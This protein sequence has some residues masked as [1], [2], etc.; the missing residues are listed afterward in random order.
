M[1]TL[2]AALALPGAALATPGAPAD[3]G[4]QPPDATTSSGPPADLDAMF[5][6]AHPDDEAGTLS[7]F[8]QWNHDHDVT[9]GVITITRGEGGGNAV[10]PQEGPALGLI[11]ERE[12]RAAVVK[13]GITDVYNLD[14]VDFYY[15]VSEPLTAQV[16]DHEET[17]AKTVRILRQTR[18]GVLVTMNPAPSPGQHGNHQEAA[19]IAVEAYWA[20]GDPTRFPEQITKEGL[21]PFSPDRILMRA[22]NGTSANGPGCAKAFVPT[23]ASQTIYGVWSGTPS[24]DGRS[25]AAVERD[26]Q[27]QYAS[28]GWAGFPD[29]STN[30]A[31]LGCDYLTLVDSRTPLPQWG[32]DAAYTNHAPL[33][34][35]LVAVPGGLPLGSG[36]TVETDQYRV[37]PGAAF[38]VTVGASAP[39]TKS[40]GASTARLEVP[41]GW[42]VSG[43]GALGT[44]A[45]AG[46]S[47]A[48]FTVTPPAGTTVGTRARVKAFVET[49][50]GVGHQ[51]EPVLVSPPVTATQQLLPQ[52]TQYQEW[53]KVAHAQEFA[54]IV[55]PVLTLASGGSRPVD[56]VVTNHSATTQSGTV[57]PTPPAGFTMSPGTAA[58]AGLAPGAQTTVRFT[59][60]NTDTSLKTSVEGGVGGDHLYSIAATS[61]TV[62]GTT[63]QALE[64]VPTSVVPQASTSPTVDG[65][66]SAGEYAGPVLDISRR[67]E[68][69]NCT[70]AADCSATAQVTWRDDTLFLAVTVKD[71]VRGTPLAASDC[72]RHWRTD[73]VE[74]AID[75]RGT[76]ENTSTTFKA[77]ILPWTAEGGPCYL[78]DADAHQGDGPATAP[79]MRIASKVTEP[80]TGYVVETAI[81]MSLLPS[82]ID[83][84]HMGLNVLPYDS[85]TQDKTG[86]T[87]IG[88]SVWG[89]V[90]GDPYR[91]GDVSLDGYV[92]P[93]G[94]PTTP[95]APVIPTEALQSV[96]SPQSIV[97]AVRTNV[98]LAGRPSS[99]TSEAGWVEKAKLRGDRVELRLRV[100]DSGTAHITIADADGIAGDV[101]APVAEST[102]GLVVVA[103]PLTRPLA[104]QARALV[105]WDDGAGGTFSSVVSV[106]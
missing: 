103:V 26:A 75:P 81:P 51:D 88:W 59:A 46:K 33:D 98:A 73:S 95:A 66:V 94:R 23:D 68:G 64:L 86:Q 36:M 4:P 92:P 57:T 14:E 45:A 13:A 87:R 67:W 78:R 77:A 56:V 8:G 70:T 21:T 2:V 38:S 49:A 91:W 15:T 58:Y 12:E 93:A 65:V 31:Q 27:R 30:P 5:I 7:T 80:Y 11:R 28:Q 43:D 44:I 3:K 100:N 82:A 97:Q 85:D 90:Q 53:A 74:I 37:L 79:G 84:A 99:T 16:W 72:K 35:S 10:G 60:V 63:Q 89:G 9:T 50:A 39:A 106:K 76:S 6:G 52:V 55:R 40:L 34:G 71:D 96:D 42:T 25:W 102:S 54:E 83:P 24:P 41:A 61:R 17:L 104:G 29:V 48:T 18:P 22:A 19:R 62:T 20:A 69:E 47:A 1:A 105:G 32:T 101:V